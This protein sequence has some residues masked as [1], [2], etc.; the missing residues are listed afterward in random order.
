MRNIRKGEYYEISGQEAGAFMFDGTTV[1][2]GTT[3][4]LVLSRLESSWAD[5]S[6]LR[7]TDMSVIT[8]RVVPG[9]SGLNAIEYMAKSPGTAQLIVV[10]ESG[11]AV[12]MGNFYVVPDD[13]GDSALAGWIQEDGRRYV[14]GYR[15]SGRIP[16]QCLRCMG[17]EIRAKKY[18]EEE[19][20]QASSLQVLSISSLPCYP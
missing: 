1:K 18:L 4:Q 10:V 3:G 13:G 11:A 7:T 9:D 5:G 8:V 16:G 6:S 17:D 2:A 12:N 15:N 20:A 19:N 14:N